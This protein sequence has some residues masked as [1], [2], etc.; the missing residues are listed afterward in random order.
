MK[1]EY[2]LSVVFIDEILPALTLHI[3]SFLDL[4]IDVKLKRSTSQTL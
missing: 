1:A 4:S 3:C 2:L